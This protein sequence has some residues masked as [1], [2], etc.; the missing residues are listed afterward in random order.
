[1][2]RINV[3]MIM[4]GGG[5]SENSEKLKIAFQMEQTVGDHL[6]LVIILSAIL[7]G[8]HYQ[9]LKKLQL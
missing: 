3:D 1:M 5:N 9:K 6:S 4:G 8:S 7:D 2:L